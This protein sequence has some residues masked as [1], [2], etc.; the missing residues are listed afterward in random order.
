MK[1]K[2]IAVSI[3]MMG[4][5]SVCVLADGINVYLDNNLISFPDAQPKII[6]DRTMVPVRGLFEEMGFKIEWNDYSK[7][8]TLRGDKLIIAAGEDVLMANRT[9]NMEKVNI[10]METMPVIREG[11][12]YLPLRTISQV[13]GKTVDWDAD[14]KSVLISSPAEDDGTPV[15]KEGKMTGTA[16][17]YL[18]TIFNDISEIRKIV[19]SSNDPVLMRVYRLSP[20]GT[21]P[22]TGSYDAI[23]KYT[24]AL[25]D[26]EAPASLSDVKKAVDKYVEV[27][28]SACMLGE[29]GAENSALDEEEFYS[30]INEL[31]EEKYQISTSEFAVELVKY[32]NDNNVSFEAVFTEYCLDV[33]N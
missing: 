31:A 27:I 7:I 21:K 24:H 33:M 20:T 25:Y 26:L 22:N 9:S 23:Y 16:E 28:E 29:A 10:S 14:T 6:N 3:L 18:K 30:K 32:F 2:T 8:A 17:E 1:I 12:L 15:S 4:I 5:T 19:V 11:R 13:T